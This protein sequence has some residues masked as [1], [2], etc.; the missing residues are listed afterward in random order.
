MS[1][2]ASR[3]AVLES[4]EFK[5]VMKLYGKRHRPTQHLLHTRAVNARRLQVQEHEVVVCAA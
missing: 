2:Q 3:S 1:K 5:T 4:E